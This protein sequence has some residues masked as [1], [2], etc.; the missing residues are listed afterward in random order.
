M[1]V[2]V[3][4]GTGFVGAWTAKAAQDAGHQVRFLVRNADRLRT[5]A[6]KIGVDLGDPVV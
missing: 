5:S 4:G 6:E 3:T 1:R 2:L